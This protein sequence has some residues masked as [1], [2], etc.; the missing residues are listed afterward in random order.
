MSKKPEYYLVRTDAL[1]LVITRVAEAR[2]LLDAGE[3]ATVGDACRAVDISRSAYYKYKDAVLPFYDMISGRIVTFFSVIE[4][5]PGLLSKIL[6]KFANAGVNI[7]TIN[8]GIPVN[9]NA[10]L[11]IAAGR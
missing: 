8:Q 2:R 6:E 3:T 9:G 5:N 11:T 10:Q 1:P 7:L 4:D